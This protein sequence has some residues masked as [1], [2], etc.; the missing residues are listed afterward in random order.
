MEKKKKRFLARSIDT[1]FIILGYECNLACKYCLQH[2]PEM[3]TECISHEINPDIYDFIEQV[4]EESPKKVRLQ[5]FGGEPLVFRDSIKKIVEEIDRRKLDVS[6]SLMTNGKLIS[7]EMVDLFNSHNFWVCVSWDGINSNR[8]RMYDAFEDPDKK[9]LLFQIKDLGISA[10]LSAYNYP[11]EICE[12]FQK[13]SAEYYEKWNKHLYMNIDEVMD[14]GGVDPDLL[15]IDY[16]RVEKEMFEMTYEYL[17]DRTNGEVPFE[18][19]ARNTFINTIYNFLSGFYDEKGFYRGKYRSNTCN[20]GNGYTTLN[21]GL[22]G[23]LYP[24]H[25]TSTKC[26]TIYW[27]Y[28]NYLNKLLE[29]D[30]TKENLK[31]CKDCIALAYCHTGCKMVSPERREQTYCKLK[32]AV[33]LP[34]LSVIQNYGESLQ[35]EGD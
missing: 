14:T 7:Q 35:E 17:K 10:V 31:T 6:W 22:D 9:D 30:N 8:T 4:V 13:L 33:F 24:C 19:Y 1:I 18:H 15:D 25:N 2:T 5:F 26:G 23:T 21:L 20:C 32:K 3:V 34:V 28:Q 16:D 11:L 29:T 12:S 27:N